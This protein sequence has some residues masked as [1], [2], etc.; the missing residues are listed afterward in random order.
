ME[1]PWS[2]GSTSPSKLLG[3]TTLPGIRA[4][5]DR[6]RSRGTLS[7]EQF[8]DA[9]LDLLGPIDVQEEVRK[10]LVS[11]AERDGELR[12]DA[13]DEKRSSE[14]RIGIML[15]LIGASREYQFA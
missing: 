4:I 3:D 12:W 8:V 2:D 9:C 7:S 14:Q 10:Q 6:L 13:D 11:R 15:A 1:G 5:I